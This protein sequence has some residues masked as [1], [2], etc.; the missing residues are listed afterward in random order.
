VFLLGILLVSCSEGGVAITTGS[1]LEFGGS[2]VGISCTDSDGK[3]T[4]IRGTVTGTYDDGYAFQLTDGCLNGV[5][6]EFYCEGAVFK[7]ID[8]TC[9]CNAGKCLE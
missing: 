4:T 5:L 8:I 1:V 3:D 6:M 7:S 9:D 2:E